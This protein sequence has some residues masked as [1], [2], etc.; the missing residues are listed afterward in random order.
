MV[1]LLLNGALAGE[2]DE[3]CDV[4]RGEPLLPEAV[5]ALST[6]FLLDDAFLIGRN[7]EVDLGSDE[8]D[9]GIGAWSDSGS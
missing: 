9:D 3:F 8:V 4:F 2:L 5:G 6:M 7:G 1:S